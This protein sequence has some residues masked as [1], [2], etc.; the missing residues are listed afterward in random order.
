MADSPLTDDSVPR[1]A[2]GALEAEVD[3]D[4]VLLGPADLGF[5]GASGVGDRI[6]RLLDGSRNVRAL[7]GELESAYDAPDGVIRAETLEYLEALHAAGLI[8]V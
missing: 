4:L 2:D 6:W 8:T 7:V 5:F 1:R 3:G